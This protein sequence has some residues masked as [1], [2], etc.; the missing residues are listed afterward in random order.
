METPLSPKVTTAALAGAV[1][2]I[3]VWI[4]DAAMNIEMPAAVQGALTVIIVAGAAWFRRD[5][6]RDA[7]QAA[8]E[9]S[10]S[11][12]VGDLPA[13]QQAVPEK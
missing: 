13:V 4:L 3:L 10:P 1:V 5:P 11:T 9:A 12:Q 7:G 8:V 6:L 2:V